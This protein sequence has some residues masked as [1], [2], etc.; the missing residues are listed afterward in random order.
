MT[1]CNTNNIIP[2]FRLIAANAILHRETLNLAK[3]LKFP[4]FVP[5]NSFGIIIAEI[6][7]IPKIVELIS[8]TF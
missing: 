6:N 4:E 7:N 8:K 3:E 1:T 5:K 2:M